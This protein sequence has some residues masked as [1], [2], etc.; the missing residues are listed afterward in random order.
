VAAC[1]LAPPRSGLELDAIRFGRPLVLPIA[2]AV[3]SAVFENYFIRPTLWTKHFRTAP[4]G[5]TCG[6]LG[7]GCLVPPTSTVLTVAVPLQ[8]R[9]APPNTFNGEVDSEAR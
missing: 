9:A 8:S 7:T 5:K 2:I 4:L 1:R 6:A 3:G